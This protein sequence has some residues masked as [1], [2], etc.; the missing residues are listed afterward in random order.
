MVA[1]ATHCI[2]IEKLFRQVLDESR[3]HLRVIFGQRGKDF[4]VKGDL[5]LLQRPNEFGVGEAVF[6]NSGIDAQGEEAAEVT[7]FG[8]AMTERMGTGMVDGLMGDALFALAVET[9]PLGLGKDVLAA[10]I[11]HCTSFYSSHRNSD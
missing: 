11:F 9:V 2:S 10:L 8:A 6:A 4:A 5:A 7:L 3:E 1:I